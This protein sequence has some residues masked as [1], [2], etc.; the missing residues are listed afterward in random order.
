MP[1]NRSLNLKISDLQ[2]KLI[3]RYPFLEN[4]LNPSE[5]Q[6]ENESLSVPRGIAWGTPGGRMTSPLR[7]PV[8]P[9]G[10]GGAIPPVAGPQGTP[11]DLL[12]GAGGQEG[13]P[14]PIRT[15]ISQAR[16]IARQIQPERFIAKEPSPDILL[17]AGGQPTAEPSSQ[18]SGRVTAPQETP[19][20]LSLLPSLTWLDKVDELKSNPAKLIPFVSSGVEI[21]TIGKLLK[22]A[23]DLEADRE[24]SEEDLLTLKEYVARSQRDKDWGYQVADVISNLLPFA[25]EF[26]A[27]GGIYAA[28]EKVTI[29]ASTE[30]LK[31]IATK[32]GVKILEGKLAQYGLKVAGVIGGGT[33]RTLPVGAGRAVAGTLEKQLQ[34]TLV[35]DEEPVWKSAVKAFGE[36]WVEVVSESTGGLFAPLAAPIKG[37]LMKVA[38]FKAFLKVNPT[39]QANDARKVFEKLGY[40]GLFGEVLEE[41]VADVGHGV[42]TSLGLGDQPFKI[43]SLSQISVELASFSVP[44]VALRAVES[45]HLP[46][47]VKQVIADESGRLGKKPKTSIVNM[48]SEEAAWEIPALQEYIASHPARDMVKYI[49]LSGIYKGEMQDLT[50]K[51]YAELSG[52][53]AIRPNILT[54]DK[55]HVKWEYVLDQFASERGYP[56][57]EA[58]KDGIDD[59]KKARDRLS[60]LK[61]IAAEGD[62]P[63]L[64]PTPQGEMAPGVSVQTGLPGMGKETAQVQM[65]GEAAG[66]GVKQPLID[67]EKIKT[68]QAVATE[69]ERLKALGQKELPTVAKPAPM[70]TPAP[71]TTTLYRGE[72]K[73]IRTIPSDV[74]FTL[75]KYV[76][77]LPSVEG[78]TKPSGIPLSTSAIPKVAPMPVPEITG[79][80]I[81]LYRGEQMPSTAKAGIAFAPTRTT[82]EHYAGPEGKVVELKLTREEFDK[83]PFVDLPGIEA[84]Q[85]RVIYYVPQEIYQKTIIPSVGA[86]AKPGEGITPALPA[87]LSRAKPRYGYRDRNFELQFESDLD[88]ALYVVAAPT[89][90]KAHDQFMDYLRKVF[91]N[92]PDNA[93]INK[94]KEVRA[95]IKELA[96]NMPEDETLIKVP[97]TMSKANTP[98]AAETPTP[99]SVTKGVEAPAVP[100]IKPPTAGGPPAK[101]LPTSGFQMP[102]SGMQPPPAQTIPPSTGTPSPLPEPSLTAMNRI[103]TQSKEM[104]RQG[105]KPDVLTRL[106]TSKFERPGI[107]MMKTPEGKDV[108]T[109]MVAERAARAEVA[110]QAL[111]TRKPLVSGLRE[112]FGKD[113]LRGAKSDI[114]FIGTVE[115]AT[116]PATGTL[117]DMALNPDLYA[118]NP[119]Q[120]AVLASGQARNTNLL[121]S[122][123]DGYGPEIHTYPVKDGAMFLSTLESKKDMIQALTNEQRNI[124]KAKSDPRAYKSIRERLAEDPA[125][126]PEYDVEKILEVMDSF[127]ASRAAGETMRTVLNGKTRLEVMEITHPALYKKMMNLRKRLTNLQ[128]LARGKNQDIVDAAHA[129]LNSPM[130]PGDMATLAT[131]ISVK[132]KAGRYAGSNAAAL[133]KQ[134]DGIRTQ[135]KG[136]KPYWETANLKPYVYVQS[137]VYRYFPDTQAKMISDALKT[138]DNPILNFLEGWKGGSFS[139]DAS[140]ITG[141]QVPLAFGFMPDVMLKQA[142]G[143]FAKMIAEKDPIRPFRLSKFIADKNLEADRFTR[144][145]SLQGFAPGGTVDEYAAGWLSKIPK[146]GKGISEYTNASYLL[147]LDAKYGMWKRQ[148][149]I[150]VK[151]GLAQLNAEVAASLVVDMAI[152]KTNPAIMGQ[153]AARAKLMR[154][155]P[156]S[157]AFLRQ[158][159]TLINKA[160]LGYLKLPTMGKI[161]LSAEENLAVRLM[162]T[163]AVTVGV[164]SV[165]SNMISAKLN[166]EDPVQAAKDAVNPD[167]WN[168]NFLTLR[169]GK[170]KVPL[171]GF[172]RSMFRAVYPNKVEGIPFPVPFAGVLNFANNRINPAVRTQ[173][174]LIRNEDWYGQPIRKGPFYEQFLRSLEYEMEGVLPL[175]IGTGIQGIRTGQ[176]G[177]PEQVAG[178]FAGVNVSETNTE[179]EKVKMIGERYSQTDLNKPY[180]DLNNEEKDTL[181]RNHPDLAEQQEVARQASLK[182]ASEIDRFLASV[183]EIADKKRNE[184]L[185]SAAESLLAGKI[186]KYDYDKQRSYIRPYYSGAKNILWQLKN[187]IDTNRQS[188]IDA[189]WVTNSKPEDKA[190]QDYYDYREDLLDKAG[191]EVDWDKITQQLKAWLAINY[192]PVVIAYV[193]RNKDAWIQKLGPAAQKVEL[194]RLKGI[195]DDSWW[196]DYRGPSQSIP[197]I[198]L[199]KPTTTPKS[200]TTI[201]GVVPKIKVP[202]GW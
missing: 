166:D 188:E 162:T 2:K 142:G 146:I 37:Q 152:P 98:I 31:R 11:A 186:T 195:P 171:G 41:R 33:L 125:F 79:K 5:E 50:L 115:Q 199:P 105:G 163:L 108:L 89:R 30:A 74:P 180:A 84:G 52:G 85:K 143:S 155:I 196:E 141:I 8:E 42:L 60:E 160:I 15:D 23:L 26:L 56:D 18:V 34:H 194:M 94:A 110:T 157:Y 187:I 173:L 113:V 137:G 19:I 140:P 175:T 96:K 131:D 44:G 181:S 107:Q 67:A 118:L 28:G 101:P 178:Q 65:F 111:M 86:V 161:P 81:T 25:G 104:V 59:L 75:D 168:G 32:T 169:V 70:P 24:V 7:V 182:R 156:T 192:P 123:V 158:P 90:S 103:I 57:G 48:G 40:H 63:D 126:K 119:A 72:P 138:S 154:A 147:A 144:F 201:P 95:S 153:S 117:L 53:R 133:Q 29:K 49:P 129:F 51:Q 91:P 139:A 130:D 190:L 197:Y 122:V 68:Q 36:Q 106:T 151:D 77:R 167:P 92:T 69:V 165:V 54:P 39:A 202:A 27:T 128:D 127:K 185:E 134:I 189:Y 170:L 124:T 145:M 164:A 83:L 88:R 38:A 193:E 99:T 135:I 148:G 35:G 62:I 4:R 6:P 172:Y 191:A 198:P 200:T 176:K 116:N 1:T 150:L 13:L 71:A 159:T 109:G 179:S 16:R 55:K 45:I 87:S 46:G 58:L 132:V 149:D 20:S 80:T 136:L 174:D 12:A 102:I 21:Y 10:D 9:P 82:A 66:G 184:G 47:V 73:G 14:P 3:K 120:K 64:P 17:E 61:S 22:T 97:P 114:T 76:A 93:I 183:N 78:V 112:A 100:P 43:P 121:E 177:I